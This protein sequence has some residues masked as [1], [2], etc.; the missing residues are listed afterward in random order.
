[1]GLTD[2]V[3]F[4][5]GNIFVPVALFAW[6]TAFTELKMKDKQRLL[7]VIFLIIAVFYYAVFLFFIFTEVSVI[8]QM[9]GPVDGIYNTLALIF[10]LT[11]LF[12]FVITGILF[13]A[14]S[15]K[16]S[17]RATRIKGGFLIAAFISFGIGG[18]LDGLKP[19]LFAPELLDIIELI[20]RIILISSAIEFYFGFILPPFIKNLFITPE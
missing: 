6:I 17:D 1:V 19:F 14:E 3:Y 18:G 11:G 20:T 10:L 5:I 9:R 2:E 12:T 16:S 8:G 13:A 7:Q 4:L 15:F